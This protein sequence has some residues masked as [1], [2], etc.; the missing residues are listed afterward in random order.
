M[1]LQPLPWKNAWYDHKLSERL[2]GELSRLEKTHLKELENSA[3]WT[4]Q[5]VIELGQL[6][7]SMIHLERETPHTT[8]VRLAFEKALRL[9]A[10]AAHL[11]SALDLANA[12]HP[13]DAAAYRPMGPGSMPITAQ[14]L[15]PAP[16]HAEPPAAEAP[17]PP[18]ADPAAE[19]EAPTPEGPPSPA[20][21][22]KPSPMRQ[23]ILSL[24]RRGVT[25]AE[26]EV[27]TGQPR[28]VIEA[29]LSQH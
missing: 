7:Q 9:T 26:I 21:P 29:V 6:A 24:S 25:S 15:P 18:P 22:A 20:P 10:L 12:A 14:P 1:K 19:A 27:I 23:T 8:H 16:A 28:K 17:E 2:F 5:L 4:E 3:Q 11:A 13:R